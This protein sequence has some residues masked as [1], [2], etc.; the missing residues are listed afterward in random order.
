M[1]TRRAPYNSPTLSDGAGLTH[2][3]LALSRCYGSSWCLLLGGME[4]RAQVQQVMITKI[5]IWRTLWNLSQCG[6]ACRVRSP[7][8]RRWSVDA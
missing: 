7:L 2:E 3:Q 1:V 5:F 6:E 8:G 4:R